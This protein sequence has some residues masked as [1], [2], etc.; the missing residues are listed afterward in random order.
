MARHYRSRAGS[1][2][3]R[4]HIEEAHRLSQEL[5]GSDEDVKKYFFSLPS[6][7]LRQILEAYQEKYGREARLYAEKTLHKW[8]SGQVTMSGMVAS[9]LFE[10]LPPRMPLTAKYALTENL[11]RHFGPTSKKK[12]L[13]GLNANVEDVIDTVRTHIE[14][15]VVDY[16]IASNLERRFDW[17]AAGD[18]HT[19]QDLLNHFRAMEKSLVVEGARAQVPIMLE[20]LRGNEGRNTHRLAQVLK[21]GKHEL[22]LLV[23]RKSS[24]VVLTEPSPIARASGNLKWLWLAAGIDL[25]LYWLSR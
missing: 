12:L 2:R 16:K 3:A 13:I 19:K 14:A 1:E 22:E 7:Q 21:I 24:G 9:R 5:G 18:V 11:L 6:N 17:L 25:L 20:H 15:V 4:R 10:L 8:R 23:D